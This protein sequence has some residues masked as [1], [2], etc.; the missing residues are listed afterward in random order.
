MKK[1]IFILYLS[2]MVFDT[3]AQLTANPDMHGWMAK[4]WYY[5]WRLRNDFMVM[6]N[7]P[8]QSLVAE[9]RNPD[10]Y[11]VIKWS[12]AMIMHGY[13]L[14]MLAI[15]NKL[16]RDAGRLEDLKNNELELYFAIKAF[17]RVDYVTETFYSK[18][19]NN[20]DAFRTDDERLSPDVNG[21]FFRDDVPPD[22]LNTTPTNNPTY[23][24]N[25]TALTTSKTGIDYGTGIEYSRSDYDGLWDHAFNTVL[26][27]KYLEPTLIN[28]PHNPIVNYKKGME[29]EVYGLGQESIDQLIRLL[30]GFETIRKSIPSYTANIDI[31]KDG[32]NDV[33]MDFYSE[34]GRHST[35][36]IGHLA[37]WWSGT[38]EIPASLT[39]YHAYPSLQIPGSQFWT[40]YNPREQDVKV[41]N[42]AVNFMPPI[43]SISSPLFSLNNDL[44][45]TNPFYA[46]YSYNATASAAWNMG[47]SGYN[48]A[49]IK[50]TMILKVLSNSGWTWGSLPRHIYN[51]TKD[52]QFHG[53]FIPLYDYYWGWDPNKQKDK[54]RKADS[55]NFAYELLNA[56][57]CIGPYNFGILSKGSMSL[58][59]EIDGIPTYWNAP[60]IFDNSYS[61]W[62]DGIKDDGGIQEGWFSGMD[63][64]FLHNLI[65]AN[66]D[67]SKPLYH[68][69]INRIVDYPINANSSS[70]LY[71]YSAE[72][73][74]IGAFETLK[75]KANVIS[76]NVPI[77]CKA[78][79]FVQVDAGMIDPTNTF[80][81]LEVGQITC[82]NGA[83]NQNTPYSI[84]QCSSCGIEQQIGNIYS[85]VI[86]GRNL[87]LNFDIAD[88][89]SSSNDESNIEYSEEEYIDEK[90]MNIYPNPVTDMFSIY[91]E[92]QFTQ[93]DLFNSSGILIEKF[94]FNQREFNIGSLASGIY[95]L[96]IK[97]ISNE[98][99]KVKVVKI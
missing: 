74:L 61:Q 34:A 71:A 2:V 37:G 23:T 85:P 29:D 46:F 30:M 73:H 38:I 67:G 17:E 55:Y 33:E 15:E 28:S 96:S 49:N 88:F 13:Y 39:Q 79:E 10:R 51:K 45:I 50:M 44:F 83:S 72:G 99:V 82:G 59:T 19:L 12:D 77:I 56:A 81:T 32:I 95:F 3:K 65:Y 41:G 66:N 31:N 7:G 53:F 36:I 89:S 91:S 87:S 93:I 92:E 64:M 4:Y 62:D 98:T 40:I 22:F 78:L 48:D 68:D 42:V 16:L 76:N 58:N 8:G 27:T 69:L 90:N 84:N 21:Y 52:K 97:T 47:I 63:Y 80:I 9:V 57:P 75:I 94:D 1:L 6:G 18:K 25:H 35:N 24:S 14:S 20:S 43:Q 86:K 26:Q 54:D 60:Y 5:R 11:P 70:D